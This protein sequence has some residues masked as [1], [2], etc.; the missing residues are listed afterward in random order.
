MRKATAKCKHLGRAA[1]LKPAQV[2]E[3]R[4]RVAAGEDK[5]AVA[6]DFGSAVRRYITTW[7]RD[8][9]GRLIHH[10]HLAIDH[11]N[12]CPMEAALEL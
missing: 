2:K 9:S 12:P 5:A 6:K 7:H 8:Q 11:G 3:L 10:S 4:K 1:I